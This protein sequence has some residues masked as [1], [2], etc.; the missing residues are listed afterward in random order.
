MFEF[1]VVLVIGI[2]V[3]YEVF[4]MFVIGV[5]RFVWELVFDLSLV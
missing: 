2:F 5:G 3:F 1:V 4:M